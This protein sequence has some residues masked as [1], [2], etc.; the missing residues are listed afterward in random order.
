MQG[1]IETLREQIAVLMGRV[2]GERWVK[3][4]AFEQDKPELRQLIQ[5]LEGSRQVLDAELKELQAQPA[6]AKSAVKKT[7]SA[8]A[9]GF[10]AL[11][12]KASSAPKAT[13][14]S[15]LSDNEL[16]TERQQLSGALGQLDQR[17]DGIRQELA[18]NMRPDERDMWETNLVMMQVRCWIWTV[19]HNGLCLLCRSSP[20]SCRWYLE[21]DTL[22]SH[23]AGHTAHASGGD[24]HAGA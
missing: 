3:I 4:Q 17:I 6:S 18:R 7:T 2:S 19:H 1:V 23:Y 8:F 10:G 20:S 21:E 14:G 22:T 15:K 5:A 12:S 9:A 24:L 11:K 16:R 13:E